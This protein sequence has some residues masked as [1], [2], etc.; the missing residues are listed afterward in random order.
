[1][2]TIINKNADLK[3]INKKISEL[4]GAKKF[5]SKKHSGVIK[6]DEDPLVVQN[7]LRN[8]WK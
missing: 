5:N 1:M 8:E 2:V 4:K 7:K 3:D 6:L